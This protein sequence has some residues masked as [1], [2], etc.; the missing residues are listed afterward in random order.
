MLIIEGRPRILLADDNAD[1]RDYVRR[2]LEP[3]G[4]E[5]E[6]V[7]GEAERAGGRIVRPAHVADWGGTTGGLGITSTD[8]FTIHADANAELLAIEVPMFA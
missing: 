4:Y 5:V 2:I 7:L 3:A 1:M 6:A 8:E